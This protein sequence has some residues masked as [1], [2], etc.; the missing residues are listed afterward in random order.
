MNNVILG[1][2]TA[3]LIPII[4]FKSIPVLK[5]FKTK[6]ARFFWSLGLIFFPANMAMYYLTT[7]NQA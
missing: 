3:A 4:F 2:F 1:L 7:K 5:K 6:K